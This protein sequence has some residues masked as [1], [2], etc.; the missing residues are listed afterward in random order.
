MKH[1]LA[2]LF[3]LSSVII[4]KSAFAQSIQVSDEVLLRSNTKYD[5]IG[6]INGYIITFFEE[7][8]NYRIRAFDEN[9]REKW[10]EKLSL[11]KKSAKVI[12][13]T[14]TDTSFS[15]FYYYKIRGRVKLN[16]QV[17]D[18]KLNMLD[19]THIYWYEK[20]P[21]SPRPEMY[22]SQNEEKILFYSEQRN[23]LYNI[24]L[25]DTQSK[26]K[27]INK[28]INPPNF[29]LKSDLLE[30]VVDNDGGVHF[31]GYQDNKRSKR[32]TSRLELLSLF[33]FEDNFKYYGVPLDS[34]LWFDLALDYDNR[35]NQLIV[36]GFYSDRTASETHGVFY[37]SINPRTSENS[38]VSQ[39]TPFDT[40]FLTTLMGKKIERNIG[41]GDVNVQ[42]LIIRSDGGLLMLGERNRKYVRNLT[43]YSAPTFNRN[44]VNSVQTDYYYDEILLF[45]FHPTGELH[46]R[47]V[48]HKRQ[49]SQDDEGDFS[50]FGMF[51]SRRSLRLLYNDRIKIGEAVYEYVVTG[52]GKSERNSLFNTGEER[53]MLKLRSSV[54]ISRDQIVVPSERKN[55]MRLVQLSF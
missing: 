38:V 34:N 33:E 40:T 43:N 27:T 23:Q 49:F 6:K 47:E 21:F 22:Y 25:F 4:A 14:K 45:S 55:Y 36:G 30:V 13:V 26:Q 31:I 5:I 42:Q 8:S 51:L 37:L 35:N 32:E 18:H 17:L 28:A 3:V 53:L 41:F 39:F 15:V 50:S 12:G 54:Q 10:S 46:W 7:G 19:S 44:Y 2:F 29:D 1:L 9:L 16:V 11:D 24:I 20:Q 52:S 48:L